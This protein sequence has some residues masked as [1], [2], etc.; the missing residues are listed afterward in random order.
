MKVRGDFLGSPHFI[1]LVYT[2]RKSSAESNSQNEL[3]SPIWANFCPTIFSS[4]E[5]G[6]IVLASSVRPPVHSVRPSVEN[7]ISVPIG[8]I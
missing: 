1:N 4:D 2:S 5:V 3:S 7:H 6:D 8:Q